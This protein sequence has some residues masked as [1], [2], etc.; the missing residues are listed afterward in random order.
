MRIILINVSLLAFLARAQMGGLG[1][2]GGMMGGGGMP[3]EWGI[4]PEN[5]MTPDQVRNG[6]WGRRGYSGKAG[7]M[8]RKPGGIW[9]EYFAGMSQWEKIFGPQPPDGMTHDWCEMVTKR[10]S[11]E[12]CELLEAYRRANGF[13]RHEKP[14]PEE[15]AILWPEL[16]AVIKKHNTTTLP[17]SPRFG[18]SVPSTS[19]GPKGLGAITGLAPR[20]TTAPADVPKGLGKGLGLVKR[21]KD[22]KLEEEMKDVAATK[23]AS[24]SSAQDGESAVGG[25]SVPESTPSPQDGES[26]VGGESA[27]ESTP[28]PQDGEAAV[29]EALLDEEPAIISTSAVLLASL[30]VSSGITFM[31]RLRC[32]APATCDEPLLAK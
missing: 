5:P 24:T 30:L 20:T 27:P 11:Q 15:A 14:N 13:Y 25:E 7:V 1:G 21:L 4:D 26:A 28:S 29:G 3:P 9:A 10:F 32:G 19:P 18:L 6:A 23:E 12:E 22:I 8:N 2:L 31:L 16:E 17:P